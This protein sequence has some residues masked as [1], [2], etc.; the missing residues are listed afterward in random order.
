MPT[1]VGLPVKTFVVSKF[2]SIIRCT[3]LRVAEA[4]WQHDHV[5]ELVILVTSDDE[6]SLQREVDALGFCYSQP[7]SDYEYLATSKTQEVISK[8][9]EKVKSLEK[10]VI[11]LNARRKEEAD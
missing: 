1:D 2:W 11:Q 3:K 5:D 4:G 7:N 9:K 6:V 10:Q 8:L